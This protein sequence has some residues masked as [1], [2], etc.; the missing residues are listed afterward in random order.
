[1][2]AGEEGDPFLAGQHGAGP[3]PAGKPDV[4]VPSEGERAGVPGVVQDPQDDV[5][6]QRLPAGLALTGPV[7]CRQGKDRPAA[8]NAFTQ[9][10]AEPV[11]AKVANRCATAPRIAV[12]G[13]GD[14]VAGGVVGQPGRQRGDQLAAAGLGQDPAA[15][16]GPDEMQLS[17]GHLPLHAQKQAIVKIPRV[18]EAVFVADQRAGHP[19]Q[20]QELVP[21]G[22]VAGQPGAFQAQHDPGPARGHPGDRL[23]ESFPVGGA[24]AGVA[25]V[26]AGHGDLAGAP[27]ERDRLAAQVVLADRGPGVV[28]DLLEAG[29][30]DIQQGRS[31][32]V[33]GG[34]LRGRGAGE[35]G[36]SFPARGR[37]VPG[38]RRAGQV[39][40]SA[41]ASPASAWMSPVVTGSG[42]TAC[43]RAAAAA[44]ADVWVLSGR[45]AGVRRARAR[46]QAVTPWP[47]STPSPSGNALAR[48]CRAA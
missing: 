23:L 28:D 7:R 45:A 43:G 31:G 12:T 26:D 42:S 2:R 9:A 1:V 20:P 29:L 30:A 25:L 39:P 32:Q 47:V 24:G 27:A 34:H 33:G 14:D 11:A 22:G 40:A 17:F 13:A 41:T 4:A 19:A 44:P 46:R 15:Q 8:L 37:A 48:A 6:G 38:V 36:C 21:A 16:P 3:L 35:H 10:E 5:V 18:V